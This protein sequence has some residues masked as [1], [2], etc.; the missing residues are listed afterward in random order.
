MR[1]PFLGRIAGNKSEKGNVEILKIFC[2]NEVNIPL[3]DAMKNIPYFAKN[4]KEFYIN[5]K[6]PS[7]FK[8]VSMG[9]NASVLI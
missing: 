3:L 7:G 1:S 9:E 8:K 6:N 2:K 4:F 5:K